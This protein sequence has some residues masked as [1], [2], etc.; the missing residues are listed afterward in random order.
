ME[1]AASDRVLLLSLPPLEEVRSVARQLTR[2]ILVGVLVKDEVFEARKG[3][4]DF[5]NVMIVP[6]EADGT[7][8]WREDFF[9][10]IYAPALSEPS[11][12][13]LRVLAPGGTAY[14]SGGPVV[15]R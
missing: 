15:R 11:A 5:P 3:L 14:L 8:P 9:S 12:E 1:V 2:G 13:I 4:R 10:V 6:A 7:I